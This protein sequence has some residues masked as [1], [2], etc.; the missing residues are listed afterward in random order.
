MRR[1]NRKK[2]AKNIPCD[3]QKICEW[4][5]GTC[6]QRDRLCN[7][8]QIFSDVNQ[9]VDIIKCLDLTTND[10][11]KVSYIKEG[12][13]CEEYY[14]KC[15]LANE[16]E[17]GRIKPLNEYKIGFK[18]NYNCS[19]NKEKTK[20]EEVRKECDEYDMK[21]IIMIIAMN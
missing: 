12:I 2:C 15:E 17:C 10:N 21:Q 7:E 20:C 1:F 14:P 13:N 16:N 9:G 3:F 4:K 18:Q 19:Y 5:S 11:S 6:S 8:L